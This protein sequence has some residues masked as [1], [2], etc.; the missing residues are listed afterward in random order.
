LEIGEH[1]ERI[2]LLYIEGVE[3]KE[4]IRKEEEGVGIENGSLR[5]IQ[6]D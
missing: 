5:R 3:E 2:G 4:G 6:R 1:R